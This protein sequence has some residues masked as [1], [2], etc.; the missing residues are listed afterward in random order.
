MVKRTQAEI[1][2]NG[3][4]TQAEASQV[5]WIKVKVVDYLDMKYRNQCTQQEM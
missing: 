3:K 1:R 5:E 2:C 4:T